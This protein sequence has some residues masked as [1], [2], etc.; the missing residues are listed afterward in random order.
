M[1]SVFDWAALCYLLLFVQATY[2]CAYSSQP[3]FTDSIEQLREHG[4]EVEVVRTVLLNED[5][6]SWPSAHVLP[7][8]S[9]FTG[10]ALAYTALK[11]PSKYERI[12]LAKLRGFT[13]TRSG[14]LCNGTH[15]STALAP[16]PEKLGNASEDPCTRHGQTVRVVDTGLFGLVK[17]GWSW[18]HFVQDLLYKLAF[19][20]DSVD[21]FS[22]ILESGGP[23]PLVDMI[24]LA[25]GK[26]VGIVWADTDCIS[27]LQPCRWSVHVNDL[28]VV[29][30][31]PRALISWPPPRFV[32]RAQTIIAQG[33]LYA[34][35]S[36]DWQGQEEG[37]LV[38]L[39]RGDQGKCHITP[40]C[41]L[42]EGQLQQGLAWFAD[43]APRFGSAFKL[44]VSGVE[45]IVFQRSTHTLAAAALL[46]HRAVAVVAPH[47]GQTYN[48]IFSRPGTL[49]LEYVPVKDSSAESAAGPLSVHNFAVALGLSHW[50]LPVPGAVHGA[51]SAERPFV[52]DVVSTLRVLLREAM[53]LPLQVVGL[54][55]HVRPSSP[56]EAGEGREAGCVWVE[57]EWEVRNL[58]LAT[59]E[60]CHQPARGP[61]LALSL[62]V[63]ASQEP[64]ALPGEEEEDGSVRSVSAGGLHQRCLT[65]GQHTL[66]LVLSP[67]WPWLRQAEQARSDQLQ[68]DIALDG[69]GGEAAKRVVI[70]TVPTAGSVSWVPDIEASTAGCAHAPQ[71]TCRS[72][73]AP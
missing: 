29:E 17:W 70:R 59:R 9:T 11:Y 43:L 24:R 73:T 37:K 12:V 1:D 19:C 32:R 44:R 25:A 45:S 65:P 5:E 2:T 27:H 13:I 67:T 53:V 31:F 48:L 20:M 60:W 36:V 15:S 34:H 57:V 55:C 14:I 51:Q 71:A 52:V 62:L 4:F 8:E 40:R 26:S 61:C 3:I 58:A 69:E 56:E 66:Q 50:I 18:M 16:M 46:L 21:R 10:G 23:P 33:L 42:N 7:E 63:N 28:Y 41:V 6:D 54:S 39:G 49:F 30:T 38:Y 72:A 22:I 68:V 47:G 64:V 35:E